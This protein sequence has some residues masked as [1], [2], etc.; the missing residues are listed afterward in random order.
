MKR[1]IIPLFFFCLLLTGCPP[2]P[3]HYV[4]LYKIEYKSYGR[5]GSEYILLEKGTVKYVQNNQDTIAR[6]L[7]NKHFRMLHAYLQGINLES[8]SLIEVPSKKH[9]YDGA[10]AT[11]L[12][13]SDVRPFVYTSPTFDDDNPPKEIK[14]IVEYIRDLAKK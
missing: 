6:Q 8:L 10:L 2:L 4:P 12:I 13:I 7:R 5:G 1:H 9:Q 11:N 14:G 3:H